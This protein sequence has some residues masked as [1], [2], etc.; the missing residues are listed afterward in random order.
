SRMVEVAERAYD[1][2]RDSPMIADTLGWI[3]LKENVNPRR[4][5]DL[6]ENAA[7]RL[8]DNK[9][10]RYHLAYG[11]FAN[12]SAD[13]ARRELEDILKDGQPFGTVKEARS[14]LQQLEQGGGR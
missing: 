13:K 10:I 3:L 2:D 4:G 8:P 14:L 7:R 6:L 1:L 5:L 9:E 12:G 11:Y